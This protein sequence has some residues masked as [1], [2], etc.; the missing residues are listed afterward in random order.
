MEN[1]LN[2]PVLLTGLVM[3]PRGISGM[4]GMLVMGKYGHL[5]DPRRTV[6]VG[7]VMNIIGVYA[8]TQLPM[9]IQPWDMVWPMLLQGF[10]VSLIF[11]SLSS[12]AFATLPA[13][14]S[15]EASGLFSL[16]R[17]LGSSIG[18][19]VAVTVLTRQGQVSWNQLGGFLNPYN[20]AFHSYFTALHLHPTTPLA[21][22][23]FG[24]TLLQQSQMVA[25]D[26]TFVFVMWS[27]VLMLPF[28]FFIKKPA[29]VLK[30][31]AHM[32]E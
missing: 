27:F 12:L 1:L 24:V 14:L 5:F 21:I 8:Y 28:V 18:I 26:S 23:L 20:P 2:Y 9:E 30:P 7:I 31:P 25:F 10:G 11:T 15:V 6:I 17:T 13:D 3:A 19:S 29:G 16:L 4:L 32:G 22:Q